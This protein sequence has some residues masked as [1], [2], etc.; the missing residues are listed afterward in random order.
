[1]LPRPIHFVS[2]EAVGA[3]VG[4]Y[5]EEVSAKK[6]VGLDVV[7]AMAQLGLVP[8][9]SQASLSTPHSSI[10]NCSLSSLDDMAPDIIYES[11]NYVIINK[12]YDVRM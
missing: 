9:R 8:N 4:L 2:S 3:K 5:L 1:L 7:T 11:D 6:E 10:R 12:P